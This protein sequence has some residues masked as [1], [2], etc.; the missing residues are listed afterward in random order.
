MLI[1]C[2]PKGCFVGRQVRPHPSWVLLSVPER[3]TFFQAGFRQWVQDAPLPSTRLCSHQPGSRSPQW[4]GKPRAPSLSLFCS[5]WLFFLKIK[6]E[7][8]VI[9]TMACGA[10]PTKQSSL[11]QLMPQFSCCFF[12]CCQNCCML[13]PYYSCQNN[14]LHFFHVMEIH[15]APLKMY[16]KNV[17]KTWVKFPY[18]LIKF[19]RVSGGQHLHCSCAMW[20]LFQYWLKIFLCFLHFC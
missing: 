14:S 2:Q 20:S 18:T 4:L 17:H 10:S 3:I 19:S 6:N 12:S 15:A 7:I 11:L 1:R 16:H 13:E 5:S 9:S 8:T